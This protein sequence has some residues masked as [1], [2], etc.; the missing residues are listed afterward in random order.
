MNKKGKKV[1]VFID[2]P[3]LENDR[4]GE[5]LRMSVGLTIAENEVT[6]IL[7]DKDPEELKKYSP[8][9]ILLPDFKEHLKILPELNVKILNLEKER[10]RV[11]E[12]LRESDVI[13]AF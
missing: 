1:A 7:Q 8:A 6:V 9:H 13:I 12:I 2:L 10:E 11:R 3:I 5:A 4:F